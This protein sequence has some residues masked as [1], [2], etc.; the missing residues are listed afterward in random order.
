MK[1]RKTVFIFGALSLAV[2]VAACGMADSNIQESEKA[3]ETEAGKLG[4][5]AGETSVFGES[6]A[7]G[8]IDFPCCRNKI[9]I[10]LHGCIFPVQI[11]IFPSCRALFRM[12]IT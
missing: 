7:D 11:S 1:K 3:V 5:P 12:N 6:A 2:C 9:Q 10:Y 8:Q 4:Q